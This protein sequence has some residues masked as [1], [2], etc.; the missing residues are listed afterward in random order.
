LSQHLIIIEGERRD[1]RNENEEGFYRAERSC[2]SF[3][4]S[5]P[6]PEGVNAD[7]AN[8]TFR[9]GVLEITVKVPERTEPQRRRLEIK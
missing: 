6:L 9:D 4:R 1:E 2:G 5:I 7:D 3:Y 8:A